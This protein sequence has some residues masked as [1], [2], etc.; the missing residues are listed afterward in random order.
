VRELEQHEAELSSNERQLS[1]ECSSLKDALER[2][3][4]RVRQ[5]ACALEREI[6]KRARIPI[7]DHEAVSSSATH[8][9]PT[10]LS[11][12]NSAP[13]SRVSWRRHKRT[14]NVCRRKFVVR[15]AVVA[16]HALALRFAALTKKHGLSP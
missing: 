7:V 4:E 15:E 14:T 6:V 2:S 8:L 13:W 10:S 3:L 9:T 12:L 1:A 11:S 5:N 16:F